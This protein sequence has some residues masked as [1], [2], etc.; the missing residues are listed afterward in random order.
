MGNNERAYR[1]VATMKKEHIRAK[2]ELLQAVSHLK[3][4]D[5]AAAVKLLGEIRNA[6]IA[7]VGREKR[8]LDEVAGKSLEFQAIHAASQTSLEKV[9]VAAVKF[10]K[11]V[12]SGDL[13][14]KEMEAQLNSL[15]LAMISRITEE[16]KAGG[17]Y[18]KYIEFYVE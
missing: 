16:E 4:N 11:D 13:R 12:T 3:N 6:L 8:A 14:G 7:H 5:E 18:D 2:T 1:N 9:L 10:F 17:V 15:S